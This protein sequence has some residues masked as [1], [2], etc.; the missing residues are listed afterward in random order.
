MQK[1]KMTIIN[2][3]Q[4]YYHYEKKPGTH[5]HKYSLIPVG[6]TYWGLKEYTNE[7]NHTILKEDDTW[8]ST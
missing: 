3:I 4:Y 8:Y 1:L 5:S 7:N 2:I 6:K